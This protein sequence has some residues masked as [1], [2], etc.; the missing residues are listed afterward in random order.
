MP[1][2]L[3]LLPFSPV[4]TDGFGEPVQRFQKRL[5]FHGR[6]PAFFGG[7]CIGLAA[8]LGFLLSQFGLL[9]ALFGFLP[10]LFDFLPALF[11]RSSRKVFMMSII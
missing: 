6:L 9:P 7:H 11:D 10:A 2:W 4:L 8:C 5:P 1:A 3:A